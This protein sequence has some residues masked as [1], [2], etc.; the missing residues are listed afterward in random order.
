MSRLYYTAIQTQ[1]HHRLSIP[2][3]WTFE[4]SKYLGVTISSNLTRTRHTENVT[5]KGNGKLGLQGLHYSSKS[6]HLHHHCSVIGLENQFSVFLRV[7]VYTGFTVSLITPAL[8]V[9][10]QYLS[11]RRAVNNRTCPRRHTVSPESSLLVYKEHGSRLRFR[12]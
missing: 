12:S 9:L 2:C 4:E 3:K 6:S 10:T 1:T 5:G 11:H 7:A 8:E